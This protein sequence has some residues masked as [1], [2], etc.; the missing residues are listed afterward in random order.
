MPILDDFQIEI[1]PQALVEVHE[2]VWGKEKALSAADAEK[3]CA[4]AG[5]LLAPRA[6]VEF[7]T[8]LKSSHIKEEVNLQ[9]GDGAAR[10]LYVG[11]KIRHLERAEE[12]AAVVCTIGGAAE[13][14]IGRLKEAGEALPACHLGTYAIFAMERV[15][16]QV[17]GYLERYAAEK[18]CGVGPALKPGSLKGWPLSGQG[19]L[20]DLTGAGR[21][22]VSCETSGLLSPLYSGSFLVGIGRNYPNQKIQ[23]LCGECDLFE[24]C[25]WRGEE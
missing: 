8:C 22:G 1:A 15:S 21:I 4:E 17:R 23:S 10:T 14:R 12:A 16:Q 9:C 11:P 3:I 24:S 5:P 19:D 25:A 2:R 18:G 7:L 20:F 6:A 13:R